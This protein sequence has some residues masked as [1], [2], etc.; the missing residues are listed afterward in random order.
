M[1]FMTLS[2]A[3]RVE[4]D[5]TM[6][7]LVTF[8]RSDGIRYIFG[9]TSYLRTFYNPV[10]EDLSCARF[11]KAAISRTFGGTSIFWTPGAWRLGFSY[12]WP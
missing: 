2:D 10:A 6:S 3:L 7:V 8:W 1:M 4:W 11:S 9:A 5:A 12:G